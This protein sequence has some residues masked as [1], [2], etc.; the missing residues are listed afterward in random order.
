MLAKQLDVFQAQK[1]QKKQ[2]KTNQIKSN[3]IMVFAFPFRWIT[4]APF[5]TNAHSR[6]AIW[7]GAL[8]KATNAPATASLSEAC[9]RQRATQTDVGFIKRHWFNY[10]RTSPR[11]GTKVQRMALRLVVAC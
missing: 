1:K 2:I 5:T 10:F 6:L 11:V 3:I 4:S 7:R 9:R 8:F